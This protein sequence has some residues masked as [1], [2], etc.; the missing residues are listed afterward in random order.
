M[1]QHSQ[2]HLI[3]LYLYGELEKRERQAFEL[4]IATCEQCRKDLDATRRLHVFLAAVPP[5]EPADALIQQARMQAQQA[6]RATSQTPSLTT[7][8]KDL[9]AFPA[10]P[11]PAMAFA[12]VALLVVGFLGGR[13]IPT[14]SQVAG[15][16]GNA[17]PFPDLSGI[18][19]EGV[20]V[21][22]VQFV[23][24]ATGEDV[25]MVFDVVKPIRLK[26]SLDN[27]AIQ[28]VLAY[29]MVN[30]ENPGVRLRAVGSIATTTQI[31]PER[32]V[33]AALLLALKS[34]PNDGV[35]KE[36]LTALLRYPADRSVRDVLLDVLLHDTNPGLRV[37]AI[38]GLDSL[39][40][41]GY[42]PDEALLRS[43]RHQV[44]EDE[45]MYVRVKAQSLLEGT[46]Q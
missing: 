2:Q 13:L 44:Q 19:G 20:K 21:T 23:G 42:Q 40:V 43:F 14:S 38:N 36:A 45:N 8:I 9:F 34:D 25:D 26:G 4:H 37:A 1:R 15:R 18:T 27:P 41:R 35:R 17:D 31:L 16:S 11:R 10:L 39:R 32:E 29:A 33:K 5:P 28:K 30:G 6:I 7:R 3:P 46:L 24:G 12:A 22:N